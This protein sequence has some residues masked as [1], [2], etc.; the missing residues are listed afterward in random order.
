M[1]ILIQSD[2]LT[3]NAG[4][5]EAEEIAAELAQENLDH[6]IGKKPEH[7]MAMDLFNNKADVA[8]RRV[9][10]TTQMAE[11]LPPLLLALQTSFASADLHRPEE[12]PKR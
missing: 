2:Y 1:R 4:E 11:E 12:S 5:E 3:A 9:D 8:R 6:C 10:A 7:G